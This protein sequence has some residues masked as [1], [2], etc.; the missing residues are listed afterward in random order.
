MSTNTINNKINKGMHRTFEK[1]SRN[2]QT[3]I[4]TKKPSELSWGRNI[5][6][7]NAP[8][9]V[10]RVTDNYDK[11]SEDIVIANDDPVVEDKKLKNTW[12][13]WEHDMEN[14]SWDIDSYNKIYTIGTVCEFWKLINNFDKM[15]VKFTHYF[16]MQEGITPTWE[17]P[18]NRY[19]G[20]CSIRVDSRNS[21]KA[22]EEICVRLVI[23]QITDVEND[24]TGISISSKHNCSLV[25]IWN[26]D[27]KNDLTQTIKEDILEKYGH[28]SIK[29]KSNEPEY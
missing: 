6:N 11:D 20:V 26:R 15:G 23:E 2:P 7:T 18:S 3:T 24:V 27:S 5:K 17:D 21:L 8:L 9:K 1:S 16:L 28:L 10:V 29:Y 13:L 14:R 22:F 4:N 25:K 19:G 12:V